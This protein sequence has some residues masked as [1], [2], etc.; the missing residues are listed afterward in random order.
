MANTFAGLT[1]QAAGLLKTVFQGPVTSQFNDSLP[2]YGKMANG[3]EKY[4]GQQVNLPLKVRR[5][6]GISAIAEGAQLPSIGSQTTIQAIL[7]CK[8]NYLRAGLTAQMMKAS[9][10]D[11]GAFMSAMS[12][13]ME[14]G[15]KDLKKNVSRQMFWDGTGTLATVS[16]NAVAS[17]VITCTGRTSGE[18]GSKYLDTGLNIDIYTSAGVLVVSNV[19]IVSVSGTATATVTL[20][21]PVTCSAT[22]ILV[23]SG[24]YNNE[25]QGLLTSQDGGTTSIYSV[26]RATYPIYQG[27]SIDAAGGQLSL[28]LMQQALNAARYRGDSKMT[29]IFCSYDAERYYTKLL[30]ADKR[31]M[32]KQKVDG[33]FTDKSETYL[34]FGGLPVLP[35]QDCPNVFHFLNGAT[36]KKYVLADL[37]W[38]DESGAPLIV[39]TSNDSYELRLRLWFNIFPNKPAS[40]ARL[41]NFISP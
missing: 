9:Q 24:A 19:A 11:K 32:M 41:H 14:E 36:Y 22:D 39:Q 5:N 13:E 21:V 3:S 10:T 6:P 25:V 33:S 20:S 29:D 2:L 28:N 26:N 4:Q 15:I 12:F 34:E 18:D 23:L 1:G 7:N 8:Y 27:N 35:D 16:A 31:Y 40:N 17:T 37:E 38:A 30:V